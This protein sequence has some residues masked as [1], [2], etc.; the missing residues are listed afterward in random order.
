LA[1]Q[2]HS[3]VR[4]LDAVQALAR[5]FKQIPAARWHAYFEYQY[6]SS[7]ADVLPALR[8]TRN[9]FD[10]YGHTLKRTAA[11][12]R[13]VEARVAALNHALAKPSAVV[14]CSSISHRRKAEDAGIV[15]NMRA[16]YSIRIQQLP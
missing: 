16:A 9:G 1:S 8:L 6:L 15:E 7:K 11:A 12:T 13:A 3:V 14:S 2:P 10:F 4:E 5:L